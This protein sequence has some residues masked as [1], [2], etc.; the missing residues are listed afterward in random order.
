MRWCSLLL[1]LLLSFPLAA[2]D[3][4]EKLTVS[5]GS[6]DEKA[7]VQLVLDHPEQARALF[8]EM[9][10][11]ALSGEGDPFLPVTIMNFI[12]RTFQVHRGTTEL[13][14]RLSLAGLLAPD[15]TWAGGTLEAAPPS[16]DPLL[17]EGE[18]LK[19]ELDFATRLGCLEAGLDVLSRLQAWQ[20]KVPDREPFLSLQYECLIEGLGL[21]QRSGDY[22]ALRTEG[23]RLLGEVRE[24]RGEEW[25]ARELEILLTMA[26]GARRS[27]RPAE[28]EDLL[29]SARELLSDDGQPEMKR[30]RFVIET[31]AF[32]LE[33]LR[34]GKVDKTRLLEAHTSSWSHLRGTGADPGR[35]WRPTMEAMRYWAVMLT[36]A[37]QSD[38]VSDDLTWLTELAQADPGDDWKYLTGPRL[39]LLYGFCD[40]TVDVGAGCRSLGQHTK[41]L[42]LL[43]LFKRLQDTNQKVGKA[44]ETMMAEEFPGSRFKADEVLRLHG[45]FAE[46]LGRLGLSRPSKAEKALEQLVLATRCYAQS[47]DILSSIDLQLFLTQLL[48]LTGHPEKALDYNEKTLELS[49]KL[50]YRPGLIRA[51][52]IRADLKGTREDRTEAE[53]LVEA[54]IEELGA[55]PSVNENIRKSH[56]EFLSAVPETRPAE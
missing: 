48:R 19:R 50:S 13:S 23:N 31:Y 10:T 11:L 55:T 33:G 6:G 9:E 56:L 21:V 54:Y 12:A 40:I 37:G 17:K 25:K 1:F 5:L 46:Q 38:S 26:E 28:L 32:E 51:L 43:G 53:S 30:A 4:S 22:A 44:L 24:A 35:N 36:R 34:R 20:R 7:G 16:G 52:V 39:T 2:D 3:F 42:E 18:R 47:G 45:R 29:V 41:T 27:S 14:E 8:Q 49:R 15:S